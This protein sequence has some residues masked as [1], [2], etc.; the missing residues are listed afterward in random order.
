MAQTYTL[1]YVVEFKNGVRATH[2]EHNV[3]GA[4]Y[5]PQEI[6]V[7]YPAEN[8]MKACSWTIYGKLVEFTLVESG[9]IPNLTNE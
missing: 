8:S 7:F 4:M 2:L 5:V 6:K 9:K 1:A 3:I